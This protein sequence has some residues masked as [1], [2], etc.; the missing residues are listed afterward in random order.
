MTNPTF[1]G[2]IF[3]YAEVEFLLAEAVE[4]GYSVSGTALDHYNNAIAASIEFWGGK[5]SD[6]TTYLAQPEVDYASAI[7]ASSASEPW[8]EVIGTQK[9]LALYSR[10]FEA[11]TEWRKFDYPIL[12]PPADAVS[13]TPLRY[14][15][16]IVEQTLNASGWSAA[17]SAIGGDDVGT[18][19]FWDLQ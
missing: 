4:R 16:P 2:N 7:A 10:G 8:K 14:T 12:I 19:L 6:I 11:W 9:W 18:R 1:K 3:D 17:A 15:Y 5:T 13:V